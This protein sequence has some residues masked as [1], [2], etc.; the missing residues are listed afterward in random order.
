MSGWQPIETAPKSG[1]ILLWVPGDD[2]APDLILIGA[3]DSRFGP[4]RPNDPHRFPTY[5]MDLPEPPE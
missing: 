2:I 4:N 1:L 3:K 5:W